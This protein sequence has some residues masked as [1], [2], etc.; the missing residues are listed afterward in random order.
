MTMQ[1]LHPNLTE[2]DLTEIRIAAL[3]DCAP[4]VASL[5][6]MRCCC[7]P[8]WVDAMSKARPYSGLTA[9][10]E[11]ADRMWAECSEE[12]RL[13]AFAGYSA[14][15][16]HGGASPELQSAL[17][18][19]EQKFGFIFIFCA[20]GK[21]P[22]ETLPALESRLSNDLATE[23]RNAAEQHRRIIRLRLRKLLGG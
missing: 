12:D 3:N 15:G 6:F 5:Q 14:N 13:E 17:L 10:E 23:I 16:D 8:K 11:Y 2:A 19:Y 9:L 4:E 1:A 21:T 20:N 18:R 7:S 22:T